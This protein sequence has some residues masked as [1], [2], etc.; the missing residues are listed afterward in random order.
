MSVKSR[1]NLVM[2]EKSKLDCESI[3]L[4]NP[5]PSLQASLSPH[6]LLDHCRRTSPPES[7]EGEWSIEVETVSLNKY[8]YKQLYEMPHTSQIMYLSVFLSKSAPQPG[9]Y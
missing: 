5:F 8:I 6:A 7:V 2:L 1:F 3:R 9:S 4:K